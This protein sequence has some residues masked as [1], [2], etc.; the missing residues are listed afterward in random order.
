MKT[1]DAVEDLLRESWA[2]VSA[3][4]GVIPPPPLDADDERAIE[5]SAARSGGCNRG[6]SIGL[7]VM[8]CG[9]REVVIVR[10]A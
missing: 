4:Q 2:K 6:S 1:S 7:C 9:G 8:L 10:G 3:M 5:T